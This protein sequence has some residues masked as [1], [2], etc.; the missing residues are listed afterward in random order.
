MLFSLT[1]SKQGSDNWATDIKTFLI[2]NGF[3]VV[4]LNQQVGNEKRFLQSLKTRLVDCFKQGWNAKMS[5]SDNF[6]C[7]YS[8]KSQIAPELF[9]NDQ[10]FSIYSRSK[11]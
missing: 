8:F 2:E 6:Q 1:E 3:G 10:T 4:W 7:F 9:L 5:V 11:K